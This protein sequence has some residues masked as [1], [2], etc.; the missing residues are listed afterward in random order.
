MTTLAERLG[1]G[2]DDRLVILNCDDLGSCHAAN[3]GVY[4]A[5]RDGLA[6]SASLMVPCPWARD[7]AASYR[8]DDIG[9]HLTLNC[10]LDRYRWG[11]ITHAPSLLDGDGGFPRTI[12]DVWEHADLDEVRRELRAQVERAILWGFDVSHL[13]SHMG[14]LQL[15]PEFFDVYLDLAVEFGLPLRLSGESTQRDIGFPFR[16]LAA[17]EGVV[18]PDRLVVVPG[19][20]SRPAFDKVLADLRPGVTE[21]YVHPAVDSPELRAA[22]PDWAARVDD[23]ALVT[24]DEGVR[25]AFEAAGVEPIGYRPLRDLQRAGG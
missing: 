11:P 3:V 9:V 6:T 17:E 20:G 1:H 22:T 10:E 25:R 16:R 13:D 19:V 12:T 8:G 14:A 5:L 23:L 24:E 7:A 15:R 4:E 2:P 18:F 21:L